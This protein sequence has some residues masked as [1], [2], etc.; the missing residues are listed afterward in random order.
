[1]KTIQHQLSSPPEWY[2]TL[3][4]QLPATVRDNS[5]IFNSE[6]GKGTLQYTILQEGLWI[7]QMNFELKGALKLN[8]IPK[9][10][11]DCFAINFYLSNTEIIYEDDENNFC[12]G[13]ENVSILLNSATAELEIV[14]PPQKPVRVF[15]IGFT[16]EWLKK[17]LL[18]GG[19]TESLGELFLSEEPIYVFETL[20]YKSKLILNKIDLTKSTQLNLFSSVL[21]LF[22]YLVIKLKKR[23]AGKLVPANIH[24]DDFQQLVK[25]KTLLDN[26]IERSVP[27]E[28]LAEE[29]NMSLSKFKRLFKQVFANTP[30]KYYLENRM[31]KAM[32]LL[33]QRKHSI[34]EIGFIVGYSNLSQ[35]A[36]AFKKHYGVLPSKVK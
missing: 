20:D 30:Y 14:I 11:N 8:R 29:A 33:L 5:F 21:Q 27:V 26:Q 6:L 4:K 34:S 15:S 10:L 22:D 36:K 13:F 18:V 19:N 2:E 31:G 35:F 9:E 1:M 24:Y 16:R 17:T 32:Q 28:R 12:L 3:A 25:A 7:H 23:E